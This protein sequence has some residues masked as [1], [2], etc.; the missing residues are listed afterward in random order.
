MS[1][2]IKVKAGRINNLSD[3]RY[4]AGMGVE[5][6]GFVIDPDSDEALSPELFNAITGWISGVKLV[7]E[8]FSSNLPDQK[9]YSVSAI[10]TRDPGLI[11]EIKQRNLSAILSIDLEKTPTG[12]AEELLRHLK[13][14]VLLFLIEKNES[15]HL[16]D[17]EASCI[18]KW[19]KDFP[20]MLGFGIEADNLDDIINL[21]VQGVAIYGSNEERPGFKSYD[22][23]ADIL[24]AL[25]E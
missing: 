7:G 25:E 20:V 4:C 17:N 2:K 19:S 23:M 1:L 5:M 11:P 21:G 16:N 13:D 8:M 15:K 22:E 24:E 9:A 12:E 6:M 3:A 10:Q 14:D 18:R